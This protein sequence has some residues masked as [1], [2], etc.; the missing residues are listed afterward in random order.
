MDQ[1]YSIRD[2]LASIFDVGLSSDTTNNRP[3]LLDQHTIVQAFDS[4]VHTTLCRS[5]LHSFIKQLPYSMRLR[6][7][8]EFHDEKVLDDWFV[9]S[10][11][12][13]LEL[14][15]RRDII[16]TSVDSETINQT[17]NRD[18]ST[19][20]SGIMHYRLDY[21]IEMVLS[22]DSAVSAL[23]NRHQSPET[24][25]SAETSTTQQPLHRFI[26]QDIALS[27]QLSID[28]EVIDSR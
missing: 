28:S 19:I 23:V 18:G 27:G 1:Y 17:C 14:G 4:V 11:W 8:E 16:W 21:A 2:A 22:G 26:D 3:H 6:L 10:P 20:R 12:R 13:R 25:I 24:I 7:K 9:S 15:F 5:S